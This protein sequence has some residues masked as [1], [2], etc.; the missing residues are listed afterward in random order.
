MEPAYWRYW[1]KASPADK[2]SV[3][4]YHLLAYH[5]LDVAAVGK[6]YLEK[7]P[8]LSADW[9]ARLQISQELF[10]NWF[11]LFLSQHDLGKFSYRFQGLRRNDVCL[12][13]KNQQEEG[14]YHPRH[15]TL[16]Y[17]IWE[18]KIGPLSIEQSWFG[19]SADRGSRRAWQ[20]NFDIWARIVTGHHGQP[21]KTSEQPPCLDHLFSHIDQQAA[22]Q[23][24]T[25]CANLLLPER[26]NALPDGRVV[27]EQLKPL[28]WWL[29]GLA[30]LCDWLGSNQAF[31][32]YQAIP[33]NCE[34]P[35][36]N[37]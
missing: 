21:P 34:K 26:N 2:A 35:L 15:D 29:A 9:A 12:V 31:F 14:S 28:S 20:E 22:I 11:V 10:N 24:A 36:D 32:K 33:G 25:D 1:G 3:A 7:H 19:A 18:S 30:V 4:A 16:G 37:Y 5:C 27:N 17:L 6:V 23:F 13:L 8:A